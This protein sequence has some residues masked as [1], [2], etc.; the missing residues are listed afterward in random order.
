[1]EEADHWLKKEKYDRALVSA[2][3]AVVRAPTSS[4]G[5]KLSLEEGSILPMSLLIRSEILFKMS[6]FQLC[7]NDLQSGLKYCLSDIQKA[8][9]YLRMGLCYLKL[10]DKNKSKISFTVAISC[11]N[12]EIKEE[13]QKYLDNIEK[14]LNTSVK[15]LDPETVVIDYHDDLPG[16]SKSVTMASEK[17]SGRYFKAAKPI[18][19]GDIVSCE[20]PVVSALFFEKH[21][22]HCLHC[23]RRLKSPLPCPNCSGVAF[24]SVNCLNDGMKYHKWECPYLELSIGSGMSILSFL[25]LRIITQQS[26]DYFKPSLQNN[27]PKSYEKVLNL[28]GHSDKRD[29]KD[30]LHRTLMALFLL[31]VLRHGGYFNGKFNKVS[32]GE[33]SSSSESIVLTEDEL[34]IGTLLLKFLQILQYNAHEIYE[35]VFPKDDNKTKAVTCYVALG[36]YPSSAIFNHE[37]Q[38]TLARYFSGKKIILRAQRPIGVGQLVSENYGPIFTIKTKDQRQKMLKGR[39]LFDC[40]C[41]AC[42]KDWPKLEDMVPE[43]VYYRCKAPTCSGIITDNNMCD[44]CGNSSSLEDAKLLYGT[45]QKDW[46]RCVEL[47]TNGKFREAEKIVVEYVEGMCKLVV[48]PSKNLCLAMEALRTI[49]ANTNGNVSMLQNKSKQAETK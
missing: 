10:G 11:G 28:I 1:M 48:Q 2:N 45:Y 44:S 47:I 30:F 24:C 41:I 33:S 26:I 4:K 39:Y 49:W 20:E 40:K 14:T 6:E 8:T 15:Q 7:L 25:S 43:K 13:G 16:I 12:K 9:V 21:G 34:E 29:P 22:T 23:Y 46:E 37:C 42:K 17:G 3:L 19:I 35:T 27:E 5:K 36:I 38:P 31:Q 32:G 18:A